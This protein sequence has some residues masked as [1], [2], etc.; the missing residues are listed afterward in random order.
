M[1]DRNIQE[2]IALAISCANNKDKKYNHKFDKDIEETCQKFCEK[3]KLNIT[4]GSAYKE[5]RHKYYYY[6]DKYINNLIKNR[7]DLYRLRKMKLITDKEILNKLL[8]EG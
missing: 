1:T 4:H 7:T 6:I 8:R 3:H 5:V 2:L